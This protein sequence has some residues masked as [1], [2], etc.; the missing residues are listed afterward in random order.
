MHNEIIRISGILFEIAQ[1]STAKNIL[2][3]QKKSGKEGETKD[4]K[5]ERLKK[6]QQD[7]IFKSNHICNYIK[8][9]WT[10]VKRQ[11]LF[12]CIKARL[13]TIYRFPPLIQKWSI[14]V[15]PF[16][17]QNGVAKKSTSC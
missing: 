2:I 17:S 6:Q 5:M 9:K 7:A 10:L 11:R 16:V 13:S 14:P 12:T 1:R 8:C 15:K 3:T 4:L